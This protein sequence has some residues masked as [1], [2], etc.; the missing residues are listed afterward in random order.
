MDQRRFMYM[1]D[2]RLAG[3]DV[4]I[5]RELVGSADRARDGRRRVANAG[6]Q[7]YRAFGGRHLRVSANRAPSPESALLEPGS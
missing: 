4:S 3:L 1:A 5:R 6:V 7:R 2:H